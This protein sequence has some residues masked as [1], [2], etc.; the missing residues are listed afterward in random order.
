MWFIIIIIII[1]FILNFAYFIWLKEIYGKLWFVEYIV[2]HKKWHRRFVFHFF[3][4]LMFLST[5][6]Y[7]G[8]T[9]PTL[10]TYTQKISSFKD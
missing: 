8:L 9:K 5:K 10:W 7:K 4:F 6:K 2:K 3:F 1:I